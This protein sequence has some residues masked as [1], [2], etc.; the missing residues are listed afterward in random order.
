MSRDVGSF[1]RMCCMKIGVVSD[2]HRNRELLETVVTWMVKRQHIKTLYHLGDDYDDVI[3]IGD[4]FSELVQIPGIYDPRYRSGELPAK[5]FETI[6]GLTLFLVHSVEKDAEREDISRSDIILFGHTHKCEMYLDDG[7][8]YFN[9][10][11]LKGPSDKNMPPSF[12]V[13]EIF[14][15]EVNVTIYNL[16]FHVIHSMNLIRSESGLYRAG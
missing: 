9:P 7:K 15:R 13:I 16:K 3:S 1:Q 6:L 8:L 11:H 14:D 5:Q 2:T 10:G 4:E 12:G